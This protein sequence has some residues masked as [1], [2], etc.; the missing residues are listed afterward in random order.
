MTSD[1]LV[2]ALGRLRDYGNALSQ[3]ERKVL[4][5]AIDALHTPDKAL[6][7]TLPTLATLDSLLTILADVPRYKKM[8]GELTAL[9]RD[10]KQARDEA[11]QAAADL[12]HKHATIGPELASAKAGHERKLADAQEAFDVRVREFQKS[13]AVRSD[14]IGVLEEK[15]KADAAAAE[16]LRVE[17]E[18]KLA[19]IR[20]AAA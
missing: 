17:L 4:E 16:K 15:A 9:V 18:T 20:S 5:R 2:Y 13:L 14:A 11:K 3:A 10:A 8:L 12:E 7:G 6:D 1:E 19:A